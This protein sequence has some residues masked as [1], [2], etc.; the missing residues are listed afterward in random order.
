METKAKTIT[1]QATVKASIEDVW[2]FWN[3][4]KHITQWA[5]ASDDWHTVNAEK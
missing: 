5:A 1:V 3:L 2:D 4:P